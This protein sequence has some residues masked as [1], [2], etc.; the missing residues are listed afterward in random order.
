MKYVQML[1]LVAAVAFALLVIL[2][3]GAASATV[4]CKTPVN[5]CPEGWAYQSGTNFDF[6]NDMPEKGVVWEYGSVTIMECAGSTLSAKTANWGS[7]TETVTMGIQA[8]QWFNCTATTDT[9][10][11]GELE[12][13]W[14]AGTNDGTITARGTAVTFS[15]FVS[16]C[17]NTFPEWTDIGTIKGGNP[18]RIEINGTFS[19]S[20][21]SPYR[22]TAHYTLTEPASVYV[23]GS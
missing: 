9:I 1:S 18:A 2:G 8:L 5:P 16:D 15:R 10:E 13:H 4:F 11:L 6:S 19:S 14:I 20:N 17:V 12:T 23:E 3:A 21:C 7:A 22:L